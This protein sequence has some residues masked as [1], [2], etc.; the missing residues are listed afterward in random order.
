MPLNARAIA[1]WER[2]LHRCRLKDTKQ[3]SRHSS[4][5]KR[6]AAEDIRK[7]NNG[8]SDSA[9]ERSLQRAIWLGSGWC[10]DRGT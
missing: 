3:E 8:T 2:V 10:V 6:V 4:W 5:P 1:R 9:G 7:S